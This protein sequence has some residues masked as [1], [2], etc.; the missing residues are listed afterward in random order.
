MREVVT[1]IWDSLSWIIHDIPAAINNY[2][3]F[4]QSPLTPEEQI[5]TKVRGQRSMIASQQDKL[6]YQTGVIS[7][8]S[9]GIRDLENLLIQKDKEIKNLKGT[10]WSLEFQLQTEASRSKRWR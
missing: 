2:L 4:P 8:Q 10:I 6:I 5:I 7:E 9:R 3:L 1:S